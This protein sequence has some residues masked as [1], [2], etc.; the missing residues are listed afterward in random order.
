V[1]SSFFSINPLCLASSFRSI[2]SLSSFGQISLLRLLDLVYSFV[3]V[4]SGVS[5]YFVYLDLCFCFIHLVLLVRLV[6][7]CNYLVHHRT[8]WQKSV[9]LVG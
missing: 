3:C 5:P 6:C 2:G 8:Q 9:E 4:A 7:H 1:D